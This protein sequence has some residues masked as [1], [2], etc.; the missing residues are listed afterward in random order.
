MTRAFRLPEAWLADPGEANIERDILR[1]LGL[2]R[3][4][5][6]QT[7]SGKRRPVKRG[8]LDI[9]FAKGPVWGC[10]EVKGEDGFLS[11]AQI[12]E[13]RMIHR[14]GGLAIVARSLGDVVMAG[15]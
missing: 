12:E 5:T 3:Y 15:I 14:A 1:Y 10:I 9:V 2:R 6:L 13:M 7:H 11:D 8:A 4:W